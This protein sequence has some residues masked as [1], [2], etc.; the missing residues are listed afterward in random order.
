WFTTLSLAQQGISIGGAATGVGAGGKAVETIAE[1]LPQGAVAEAMEQRANEL[2]G[3]IYQMTGGTFPQ[4]GWTAV[5]VGK[6]EGLVAIA[7]KD[8]R[9]YNF[10]ARGQVA[11]RPNEIL[12]P[13]NSSLH[14]DIQVGT[15]FLNGGVRSGVIGTSPAMCPGCQEWFY[16]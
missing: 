5:A 2:L 10:I 11:L 6:S 12:L 15:F 13:L 14:P 7:T 3:E 16:K 9:V 4:P 8:P 1:D